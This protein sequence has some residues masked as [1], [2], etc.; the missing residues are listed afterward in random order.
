MSR[1]PLPSSPAVDAITPS[2]AGAAAL[3]D[4]LM[5]AIVKRFAQEGIAIPYPTQTTF[6]AAPDGTIIM[7]YPEKA[8]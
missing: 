1:P 7:P 6:T 2:K 5:V 8:T 4:R 3:R